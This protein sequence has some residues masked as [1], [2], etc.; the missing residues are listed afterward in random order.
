MK[1]KLLYVVLFVVVR[2]D[3]KI[4]IANTATRN[5]ASLIVARDMNAATR[6]QPTT[7]AR[8]ALQNLI[9]M[10]CVGVIAVAVAPLCPLRP[11]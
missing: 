5:L 2:K 9:G 8:A 10:F 7:Q 6:S 3:A 4:S 1:E 11:E